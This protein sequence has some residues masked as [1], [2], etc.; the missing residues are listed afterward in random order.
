[1]TKAFSFVNR[2]SND[3][4]K[5]Y[6]SKTNSYRYRREKSSFFRRSPWKGA[7]LPQGQL[8][9]DRYGSSEDDLHVWSWP[10]RGVEKTCNSA[11]SVGYWGKVWRRKCVFEGWKEGRPRPRRQ[12]STQDDGRRDENVPKTNVVFL[13]MTDE[14]KSPGTALPQ[15][16]IL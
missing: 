13:R 4:L 12:E 5:K 14:R 3:C 1:M 2:S 16:H 8:F 7:L 6:A 11:E 10:A 15:Q 9:F